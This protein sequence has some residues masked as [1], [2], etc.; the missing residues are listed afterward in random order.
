[1]MTAMSQ[2][3]MVVPL[4][5]RSDMMTHNSPGSH[6]SHER[7]RSSTPAQVVWGRLR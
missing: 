1:M 6:P 5:D 2:K 3:R 4:E 7:I